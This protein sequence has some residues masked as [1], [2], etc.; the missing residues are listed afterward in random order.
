MSLT[1]TTAVKNVRAQALVG[2]IDAASNPGAMILYTGEAPV[3]VGTITSQQALVTLS[4]QKPCYATIENG[5]IT[6]NSIAEQMV[7][8]TGTTGFARLL[9]GNNVAIADMTI[10]VIGSGAD[11][12]IPTVDLIQGSYIRIT[13]GQITE[14]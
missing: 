12:E 10:G 14:G 4:L 8:T 3:G 2:L 7:Q 11:I 13:A 5:V 1:Y 6:L 9:D